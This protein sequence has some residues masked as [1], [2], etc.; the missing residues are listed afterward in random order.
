M[1]TPK[2]KLSHTLEKLGEV[3]Q[4][5]NIHWHS[6]ID[7]TVQLIGVYQKIVQW[8]AGKADKMNPEK[9]DKELR[10]A[11]KRKRSLQAW[12]KG[13]DAKS[14]RAFRRSERRKMNEEVSEIDGEKALAMAIGPSGMIGGKAFLWDKF[15]T[16]EFMLG[17]SISGHAPLLSQLQKRIN[18][19]KEEDKT[20]RGYWIP[21]KKTL[22]VYPYVKGSKHSI[23]NPDE[24]DIDG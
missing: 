24:D 22:I 21:A 5:K 17:S 11:L 8:L 15:D 20:L 19:Q 4:V 12:S 7:D 1:T 18:K 9:F 14:A 16:D 23:V 10:S 13:Q 3:F 6:G 2:R